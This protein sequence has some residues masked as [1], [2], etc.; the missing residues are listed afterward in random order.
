MDRNTGVMVLMTAALLLAVACSDDEPVG[1][2]VNRPC[3]YN[4]DC[5]D[6]VC[7]SGI[8]AAAAP[9]R[10]GQSCTGNGE[11]ESFNCSKEGKCVAGTLPGGKA[12]LN[13]QECATGKCE[14]GKCTGWTDAG[15][16]SAPPDQG[17]PD[18]PKPDAPKPDAAIPD[19]PKP[20]LAT[21]D[22]AI[23]DLSA[24]DMSLCGNGKLDPGEQCDTT[25]PAGVTCVSLGF[26]GGKPACRKDCKVSSLGCHKLMHGTGVK[27]SDV[28]NS[29]AAA[30]ASDGKDFLV[31]WYRSSYMRAARVTAAGKV[32]DTPPITLGQSNGGVAA[33]GYGGG[34]YL[35]VWNV[36]NYFMARRVTPQGKALD[37]LGVPINPGYGG[38]S[39]SVLFNGTN[40][41]VVWSDNRNGPAVYAAR[42]S[43]AGKL[44]DSNPVRVNKFTTHGRDNPAVA[45]DGTNFLVVFRGVVWKGPNKYEYNIYANRL[46]TS[47]KVLHGSDITV[48]SALGNQY[49]P[50][51]AFGKT[52]YLVA[53]VDDRTGTRFNGGARVTK[54]GVVL[55][56]NG[57]MVGYEEGGTYAPQVGHDGQHFFVSWL[58]AL[59]KARRRNEG[60]RLDAQGNPVG[61]WFVIGQAK[62]YDQERAPALAF[63]GGQYLLVWHEARSKVSSYQVYGNRFSFGKP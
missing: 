3:D 50:A 56:P 9:K 12:C 63:G 37:G 21:P 22:A 24:P 61:S 15:V 45:F 16:D 23:P 10:N 19:A 25:V 44:V 55:D 5:A 41:L 6:G 53:W 4:N 1:E 26:T 42:F 59:P 39:P 31:T 11:C 46:S 32:L 57:L 14:N 2:A 60:W 13:H 62:P 8:C 47:L 54:A 28:A 29:V 43:T 40:F 58:R 38:N 34:Y 33:V 52:N 18:A 48:S 30:V 35:V 49:L 20:D 7:H 27:I 51:V 17:K 36:G